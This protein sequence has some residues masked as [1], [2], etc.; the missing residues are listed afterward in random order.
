MDAPKV[1]AQYHFYTISIVSIF[2]SLKLSLQRAEIWPELIVESRLDRVN[3]CM[4][5][6]LTKGNFPRKAV[7][8]LFA[9]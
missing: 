8:S 3:W 2:L 1:P 9:F 4:K 7:L 5:L 6:G